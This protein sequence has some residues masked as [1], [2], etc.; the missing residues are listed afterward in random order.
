L[1]RFVTPA[2][3]NT[4]EYSQPARNLLRYGPIATRLGLVT[5]LGASRPA[6]FAFYTH[7]PPLMSI[8]AAG[9]FLVF[10][11]SE[12]AARIYPAL[13]SIGSAIVVCLLWS[14]HRGVRHGALAALVLVTLPGFGHFGRML[15]SEAPSLFFSLLTLLIH[16]ARGVGTARS[17]R[18]AEVALLAA[19]AASCLSGW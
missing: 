1:A 18:R 8:A 4:A 14:R 13:C 16:R 3:N 6:R 10:G 9:S 19:Y 15:G 11:V 7:H 17:G 5:D 2:D 12:G